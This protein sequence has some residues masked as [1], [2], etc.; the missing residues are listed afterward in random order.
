MVGAALKQVSN[1]KAVANE[2]LN[3][4][5]CTNEPVATT[6]A[7]WSDSFRDMAVKMKVIDVHGENYVGNMLI[8]AVSSV[9]LHRHHNC[10]HTDT[11][12]AHARELIPL[13]SLGLQRQLRSR[14]HPGRIREHSA[15]G[16]SAVIRARC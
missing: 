13:L 4:L 7:R 10:A 11:N 12:H 16:W 14:S 15:F 2:S 5:G 1:K 3:L 8:D 9:T 6:A